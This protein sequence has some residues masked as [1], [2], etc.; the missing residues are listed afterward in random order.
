M[1]NFFSEAVNSFSKNKKKKFIFLIFGP[2]MIGKKYLDED[3]KS[4]LDKIFEKN[5][6]K[7]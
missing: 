5:L 3:L 1:S 2:K 7:I 4:K 6:L